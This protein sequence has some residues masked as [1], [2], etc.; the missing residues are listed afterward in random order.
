MEW[1]GWC[2]LFG[3][4]VC[5][6]VLG[7]WCLCGGVLVVVFEGWCFDCVIGSALAALFVW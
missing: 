4:T 5:V 1:S 3:G 7:A 2:W 6:V